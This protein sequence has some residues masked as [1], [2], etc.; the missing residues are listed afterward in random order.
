MANL[1]NITRSILEDAREEAVQIVDQARK[2]ADAQEQACRDRWKEERERVEK[3]KPAREQEIE[4]LVRTAAERE[5]RN[6]RLQA[7]QETLDRVFALAKDQLQ[8][9]DQKSYQE[10]LDDYLSQRKLTADMVLELPLDRDYVT[11]RVQ[12]RKSEDLRSGFR[13]VR[14]GVC[15][16]F[17]FDEVV[18]SLRATLETQVLEQIQER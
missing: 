9:M 16:N 4:D 11:D 2:E 5:A 12:V 15:E 3:K 7:K 8:A 18:D 1:D 13:L 6:I 14:G 10:L 17:D